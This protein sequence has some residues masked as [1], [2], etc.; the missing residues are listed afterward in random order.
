MTRRIAVDRLRIKSRELPNDVEDLNTADPTDAIAEIDEAVTV[1]EALTQLPEQCQELLDR[2]FARDQ[3][4]RTLGEALG[5][6]AGTIASR[7]SRCP[8]KVREGLRKIAHPRF[9]T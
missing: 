8:G 4:Y 2:F 9:V 6:P 7:S 3:S 1:H 5:L